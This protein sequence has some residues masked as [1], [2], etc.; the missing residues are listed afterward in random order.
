MVG[1]G[2]GLGLLEAAQGLVGLP[3]VEVLSSAV[4][5]LPGRGRLCVRQGAGREQCGQAECEQ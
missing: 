2:V 3:L 1:S 5:E 4:H